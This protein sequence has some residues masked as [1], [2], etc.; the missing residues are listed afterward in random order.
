MASRA[1]RPGSRNL[2]GD[3]VR[4]PN[5]VPLEEPIHVSIVNYLRATLPARF[6][7][8]HSPNGGMLKGIVKKQLR[9][10]MLPGWPDIELVGRDL[11]DRFFFGLI[12]VKSRTGKLSDSQEELHPDLVEIGCPLMVCRSI[13]DVRLFVG[14]YNLPSLDATIRY[15]NSA[16]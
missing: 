7:V 10:G 1:P 6:K 4:L 16:R 5:R 11:D 3:P 8:H 15:D 2:F 9:M 12:E 14:R 13:D